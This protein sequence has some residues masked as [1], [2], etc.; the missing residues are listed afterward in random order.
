MSEHH[1]HHVDFDDPAMVAYAE[2]EGELLI[3]LMEEATALVSKHCG[4]PV[5]H[6]LDIGCGPGVGT[7]VLAEAFPAAT[8]VAVDG[9]PTMLEQAAARA[10]RLGLADRVTTRQADLPA[11]LAALGQA[12]VIWASMVLHHV[13]D[14]AAA[15]AQLRERLNPGGVLALVEK[16]DPVRVLP[17]DVDLGRPGLWARLDAAW[18]AWFGGMRAELPGAAVSDD[19]PAMLAAAGFEVLV[20]EVPTVALDPPLDER[21]RRFAHQQIQRIP[22]QLADHADPADLAALDP[23]LDEHSEQSI[24]RRDDTLVRATRHLYLARP[25]ST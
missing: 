7:A 12:D 15:L 8:I 20:D 16:A 25:A 5:H 24:L 21:A 10:E 3:S 9:S 18:H 22:T 23:L 1:H 17:A 4:A 11:D 19:Y 2:L 13:G 14:E 6:V